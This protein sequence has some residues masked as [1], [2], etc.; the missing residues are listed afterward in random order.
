MFEKTMN[1]YLL[2]RSITLNMMLHR[3]VFFICRLKKSK[4]F[5]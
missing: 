1:I 2:V 5:I 3:C 4:T